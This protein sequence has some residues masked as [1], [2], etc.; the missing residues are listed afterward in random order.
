MMLEKGFVRT[1]LIERPSLSNNTSDAQRLEKS[2]EKE[3]G[4]KHIRIP[5]Q[6]LKSLPSN[7]RSWD[8][9]A[10]AILF[11]DRCS[12]VLLDLLAPHD[13]RSVL[14]AAIDIGTTRV[15]IS[16]ID[17]ETG[18][19]IGENGFDNPQS[20]IG[21]D[22]LTRIHHAGQNT[23][24]KELNRLIIDG[25]NQHMSAMCQ[26]YGYEKENIYIVTGAGNTA[27]THLF[28]GVES[29]EIIK[30]PYIPCMNIPD[31]QSAESL[32][33]D[34]NH[35]GTVFLF[36]NIGSYFGGDLIAGILFSDLDKSHAPCLMV[37]VGTNAEIVVGSRDWLIACAGA[38]GPALE[39]GVSK[40]GM[41]AKPGVI[42]RVWIDPDSKD[43]AIHTIEN[44]KPIG[45]C[46]S[47]MIDL[48]AALFLSKRIDIRGKFFKP[49]CKD[50]L[51]EKDGIQQFILV[52]EKD[53]GTGDPICL[54]QVDLNSLT[55]SKA[56][57]YTILEV[58]VKNTAGLEFE[59]LQ[60]FYVAGTFG[61]FINP[62]SAISIGML[63]DI[64]IKTF[65]V[66]GNSS[67]GGAKIL[68]KDPE[69][70]ERVMKIQKSITYIEL[71]VNQEF[72]NMFSG[73][74][75]YPHTDSSRFPSLK[76]FN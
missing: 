51:F 55:S 66:L 57:M 59:D 11:K 20:R 36:P 44:K 8:F 69:A 34:I 54:S 29:F 45:I 2:L 71:N 50:Q 67:L 13:N 39:G 68:L 73:A 25:V 52:D 1:I 40:M 10:K 74:K 18:N 5:L 65:E 9:K 24:L 3:L 22:V 35:N 47:G 14:G 19:E 63:P 17:L 46:G 32:H 60:T 15:V 42:D 64:E 61:S 53:S 26:E 62:V 43:L 16:L 70:F 33:L 6:L 56:A 41:T 76:D 38:A 27:M 12:W 37:D 21:P 75:F 49:A 7:L 23:G 48:A 31:T 28:S 4:A 58:I 72:M 30:E